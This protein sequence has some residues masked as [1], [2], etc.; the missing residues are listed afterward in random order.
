MRRH[1]M[2]Q[3]CT[4]R[5]H[6]AAG[7]QACHALLPQQCLSGVSKHQDAQRLHVCTQVP[8]GSLPFHFAGMFCVAFFSNPQVRIFSWRPGGGRLHFA[9]DIFAKSVL[10][11][12]NSLD[13]TT[14]IFVG[15]KIVSEVR[16][17]I[18]GYALLSSGHLDRLLRV[19][20]LL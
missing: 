17:R 19:A 18:P 4:T 2:P 16:C 15:W 6:L 13:W 3:L 7:F 5:S 9:K 12:V 20:P 1:R 10:M 14:D 8:Y 11:G